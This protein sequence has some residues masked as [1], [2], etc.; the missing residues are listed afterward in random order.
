MIP[1]PVL[2]ANPE[3]PVQRIHVFP[4]SGNVWLNGGLVYNGV[5]IDEDGMVKVRLDLKEVDDAVMRMV[6]SHP[7]GRAIVYIFNARADSRPRRYEFT[8]EGAR[9]VTA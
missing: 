2:E 4:R 5:E 6:R 9:R 1:V 3:L 8:S 7:S